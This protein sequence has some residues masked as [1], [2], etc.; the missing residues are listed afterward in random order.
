MP[1]EALPTNPLGARKWNSFGKK[2][3]PRLG[4]VMVFWRESRNGWKGHVGFYWAEDADAYHILGG[5][6][7]NSVCVTRISKD[8]LLTARWPHSGLHVDKVTRIAAN[9]G[10]L[11]STNEA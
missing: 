11:L 10:R 4:A 9:N 2:T 3:S 5:N 8:R 1:D 7:A 6:Q